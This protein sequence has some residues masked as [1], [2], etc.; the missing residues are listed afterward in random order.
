MTETKCTLKNRNCTTVGSCAGCGWEENEIWR[1]MGIRREVGL[2][3]CEDGLKRLIV[4][5][6]RKTEEETDD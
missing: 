6:P 4:G 3:L 2:T 5:R 1:R